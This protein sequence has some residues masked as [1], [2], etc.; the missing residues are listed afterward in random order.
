M[1]QA[2]SES[3]VVSASKAGQ[4][5]TTLVVFGDSISDGG[6][7]GYGAG[8]PR[9]WRSGQCPLEMLQQPMNKIDERFGSMYPFAEL[10]FFEGCFTDGLPWPYHLG[11]AEVHNFAHGSATTCQ[12]PPPGCDVPI[13]FHPLPSTTGM[14][15]WPETTVLPRGVAQQLQEAEE[16][17][18]QE[19]WKDPS[20]L[21]VVAA[22]SND[23]MYNKTEAIGTSK[24]AAKHCPTVQNYRQILRELNRLGVPM[25]NI[26]VGGI[27]PLDCMPS[28]RK[29]PQAD[30]DLMRSQFAAVNE[31][32]AQLGAKRWEMEKL[33][34]QLFEAESNDCSVYERLHSFNGPKDLVKHVLQEPKKPGFFDEYHPNLLGQ[35]VMADNFARQKNG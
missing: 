21:F 12:V 19:L 8:N 3:A 1:G 13:G 34:R 32:I 23:Y 33:W 26:V 28:F 16:L 20:A 29:D 15:R 25:E 11:I 22:G 14:T 6:A 7:R 24:E 17:L 5:P 10:G 18:P 4:K 31:C 30:L 9:Y 2:L 27:L 35:Q